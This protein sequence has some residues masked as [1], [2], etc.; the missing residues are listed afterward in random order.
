MRAV[1]GLAVR[2]GEVD[3]AVGALRVAEQVDQRVHALVGR[4]DV[5][6]APAAEDLALDLRAAVPRTWRPLFGSPSAGLGSAAS[7]AS[8]RAMSASAAASRSRTLATTASGAF[9]VNA[10]LPS[11]PALLRAPSAPRRGPWPAGPARRRRRS[12][13]TGRARR[14]PRRGGQRRGG[15]EAVAQAARAAAA[16]A[17]PLRAAGTGRAEPACAA[18]A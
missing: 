1:D 17:L 9:A 11:L 7:A 4:V 18:T 5:A 13:R 15:G 12:R 10:S 3:R 8:M 6:L 14:P 2:A 16:S